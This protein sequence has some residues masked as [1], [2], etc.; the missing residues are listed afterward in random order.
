[1]ELDK[2]LNL[3]IPVGDAWV[4]STPILPEAFARYYLV[5]GKTF[6]KI[7]T[8]GLGQIA[9]PRLAMHVLRDVARDLGGNDESLRAA[10]LADVE[11]GLIAEIVRLSNYVSLTPSGWAS[12]PLQEAI[13]QNTID[14][15]SRDEV[16][17]AVAFFIVTWAMH[18]REVRVAI[19]ESAISLWSGHLVSSNSTA[20]A[21]SLPTSTETAPSGAKAAVSSVPS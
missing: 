21:A 19:I 10:S 8:G 2:K 5:L 15:E 6:A 12:V 1:M 14:E 16:L 18:L 9:G 20:F 11:N 13:S 4:H 3:V 17:N 7:Y